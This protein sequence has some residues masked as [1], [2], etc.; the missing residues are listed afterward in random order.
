MSNLPGFGFADHFIRT[1]SDALMAQSKIYNDAW[2]KI[3]TGDYDLKNLISDY[4]KVYRS[5]FDAFRGV[6]TFGVNSVEW[7]Q[8]TVGKDMVESVSFEM[9]TRVAKE[10]LAVS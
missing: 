3:E 8:K 5:N 1:L 9:P 6:V 2:R 7:Q 4:A 10:H